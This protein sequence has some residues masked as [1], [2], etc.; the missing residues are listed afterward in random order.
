[1]LDPREFNKLTPVKS[2]VYTESLTW[3]WKTK[4]Y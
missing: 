3:L 1:M 2:K 4:Q